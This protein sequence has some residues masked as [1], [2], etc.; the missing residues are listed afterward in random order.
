MPVT[1]EDPMLESLKD[2]FESLSK[3]IETKESGERKL[4][5]LEINNKLKE[6]LK[7][8]SNN[9]QIAKLEKVFPTGSRS[10]LKDNIPELFQIID[11]ISVENI[12]YNHSDLV[13]KLLNDV[14]F[15]SL[16]NL[17]NKLHHISSNIK[18]HNTYALLTISYDTDSNF[19]ITYPDFLDDALDSIKQ[20]I[21]KHEDYN[22][23]VTITSNTVDPATTVDREAAL[24]EAERAATVREPPDWLE[25]VREAEARAALAAEEARVAKD[26]AVKARAAVNEAKAAMEGVKE[27]AAW[28]AQEAEMHEAR[29]ARA[30]EEAMV[31]KEEAR[32]AK[33]EARVARVAKAENFKIVTSD[34]RRSRPTL[35]EEDDAGEYKS[36]NEPQKEWPGRAS[37]LIRRPTENQPAFARRPQARQQQ[38]SSES[39]PKQ[40]P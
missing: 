1:T 39:E 30:A 35:V 5:E 33:E 7:S 24:A 19:K 38:G 29:A 2:I 17:D 28:N 26:E 34:T 10:F 12:I 6:T 15:S 14:L 37:R 3:I 4:T 22:K 27:Q 21:D 16:T 11:T 18:D 13:N 32:V 8:N 9:T 40:G 36:G 23:I 25:A 20:K 31:A